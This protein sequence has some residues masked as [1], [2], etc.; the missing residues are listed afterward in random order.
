MQT[1]NKQGW[2]R[3]A[4]LVLVA[5]AARGLTFGNPIVQVDEEFY[6]TVAR[7]MW[8]GAVPFVDLWDRKPI[9]LF[10]VYMPAAALPGIAGIYAYQAMALAATVA[11]AWIVGRLADR[12]GWQSG[13]LQAGIAYVLWL[14]LLS[15]VG[16]QSPVFYNL[17]MAGAALLVAAPS[18]RGN[19][20]ARGLAAMAL[21]GLALQIK[22]SVVFEG[23]FIGV[24]L[25]WH[26][27]RGGRRPLPTMLYGAALIAVALVPTV[28]AI[29]AYWWLGALDQ[30]VFANFMAIFARKPNPFWEA[31]GNLAILVL[32]L[33]PLVAMGLAAWPRRRDGDARVRTF[34]LLW[35]I[36][37]VLG[38][39]G[40]GTWYDHYGLAVVA[41]ASTC[42]AWFL[43]QRKWRGRATPSILIA[44]ALAGQVKVVLDR[45]HRGTPAQFARLSEAVGRGPG[46]LYVYSGHA[47]LHAT[48]GRCWLT[49]YIFPSFLIRPRENG[50]MGVDQWTEV[51]RIMALRPA[52]IVISPPYRVE[53]LDIRSFV[54]RAAR[55][56]YGPPT[57]VTL[58]DGQVAVYRRLR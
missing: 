24:W 46:C 15:G 47:L 27:W 35:M 20:R 9:G 50:A 48:T 19:D 36:A 43:G 38:V 7:A 12:A 49:P 3:L 18:P 34:L 56:D 4:I 22:Y 5:I 8:S 26:D 16:G 54:E 55:R 33:S 44:A 41:P 31:A 28:I 52:V 23:I 37:S 39:L 53:T 58:G 10:I 51:R 30:F 2:R 6:F 40:F 13:A 11:T 17:P 29:V 32:I 1:S 21:I 25:L 42:A 14:T 57:M 45:Y